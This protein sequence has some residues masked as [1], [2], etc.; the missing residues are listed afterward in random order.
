MGRWV[1]F[2][3]D[4][5]IIYEDKY[6]INF[7]EI[8]NKIKVLKNM[9]VKF[10]I[11]TNRSFNRATIRIAKRY[12]ADEIIITEGGCCVYKRRFW[13]HKLICKSNTFTSEIKK[14]IKLKI[15]DFLFD[16]NNNYATIIKK[17]SVE[18]NTFYFSRHRIATQTV[19]LNNNYINKINDLCLS[20]R[21]DEILNYYNIERDLKHKNRINIFPNTMNKFLRMQSLFDDGEII[22]VTDFENWVPPCKKNLRIVS[23]GKNKNFNDLCDNVFMSKSNGL[24]DVLDYI[25]KGEKN[26]RIWRIIRKL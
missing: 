18:K 12:N 10:G 11:C 25:L 7:N 1:L 21:D 14:H 6:P 2:D 4:E 3:I 24:N 5:T 22:F 23:V 15:F 8:H 16:T 19:T 13:G 20:L 26:E 17:R 9:G